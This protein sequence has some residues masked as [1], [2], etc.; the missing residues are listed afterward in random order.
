MY[1]LL[2]TFLLSGTNPDSAEVNQDY[3]KNIFAHSQSDTLEYRFNKLKPD[4]NL[5]Q[6]PVYKP[7]PGINFEM[8]VFKPPPGIDFDMPI[9]G[10]TVNELPEPLF[11]FPD[12]TKNPLKKRPSDINRND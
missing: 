3:K 10:K 7:P 1:F 2:F 8:P 4:T 5:V 9:I 12:S 6:M 11:Q